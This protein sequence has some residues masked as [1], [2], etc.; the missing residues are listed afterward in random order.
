MKKKKREENKKEEVSGL[1]GPESG[2]R[3]R[4]RKQQKSIVK[5]ASG[6]ITIDLLT[7]QVLQGEEKFRDKREGYKRKG[8]FQA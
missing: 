5:N 4:R 8:R 2:C 1:K 6:R 7:G 3:L